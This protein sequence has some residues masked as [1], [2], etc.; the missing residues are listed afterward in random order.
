[1]WSKVFRTEFLKENGIC[2]NEK[3]TV[4]EDV[5]FLIE[6]ML[7]ERNGV[8]FVK[9]PLYI[10][11]IDPTSAGHRYHPEIVENDREFLKN[12]KELVGDSFDEDI[13]KAMRKR[14]V[15]CLIGVAKFDMC[16]RDNPKK[17]GERVQDLKR[18]AK[19]NPY[20]IGIKKCELGDF[21][22]KNQMKIMLLR[23][24]MESLFVLEQD[25]KRRR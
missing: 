10:R 14:Y 18:L 4:A 8:S 15:V 12:L 19:A 13:T 9:E 23:C 17:L 3:M 5:T 21:S 1:M 2:F 25:L 22:K 6:C 7:K 11:Q 16:H 24:H 20:K